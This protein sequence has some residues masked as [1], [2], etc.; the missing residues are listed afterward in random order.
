[1]KRT[2]GNV[3]RH[4]WLSLFLISGSMC[5]SP[6]LSMLKFLIYFSPKNFHG[7]WWSLP[8]SIV[9]LGIAKWGFYSFIILFTFII[10]WRRMFPS[11]TTCFPHDNVSLYWQHFWNQ[12]CGFSTK[13]FSTNRLRVQSHK[14]AAYFQCQSQ[15]PCCHLYFWPTSYKLEVPVAPLLGFSNLLEQCTEHFTY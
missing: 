1:M 10:S 11:M 6:D 3:W 12:M 2:L 15:V 4:F 8:I 14:T 13:Q 7:H 9:L 5:C